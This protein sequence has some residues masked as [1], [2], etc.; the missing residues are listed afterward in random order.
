MLIKN[1]MH[2]FQLAVASDLKLR[3]LGPIARFWSSVDHYFKN[4][5]QL[6]G[7]NYIQTAKAESASLSKW[8]C[9]H[10]KGSVKSVIH[11][12]GRIVNRAMES[13]YFGEIKKI[14]R[15]AKEAGLFE[16]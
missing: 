9:Q 11:Y 3:N 7:P 6:L 1:S 16:P 15:E 10:V 5:S 14:M 2:L 4:L 13:Y 8:R 12:V